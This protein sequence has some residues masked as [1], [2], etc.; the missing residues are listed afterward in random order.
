MEN[1]HVKLDVKGRT[2]LQEQNSHW[3]VKKGTGNKKN[4]CTDEYM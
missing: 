3:T 2:K 1:K 4:Y